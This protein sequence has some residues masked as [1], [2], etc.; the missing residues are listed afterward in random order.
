MKTIWDEIESLYKLEDRKWRMI[1]LL[2]L[3]FGICCLERT[4]INPFDKIELMVWVFKKK[5]ERI[6]WVSRLNLL[7]VQTSQASAYNP[8]LLSVSN[9]TDQ[10][11]GRWVSQSI[12]WHPKIAKHCQQHSSLSKS[13]LTSLSLNL[14]ILPS[15]VLLSSL[16][17]FDILSHHQGSH[18]WK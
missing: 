2:L 6:R 5:I 15:A 14:P 11:K 12:V 3:L 16:P 9:Q 7:S 1:L 17:L 10:D 4:W 13:R 18:S 8:T